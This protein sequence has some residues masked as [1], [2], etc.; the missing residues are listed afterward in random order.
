MN[1]MPARCH[2]LGVLPH[3]VAAVGGDDA[4]ASGRARAG[5]SIWCAWLH[6][7]GVEGGDLVVVA[8]GDDDGLRG[9]QL[10]SLRTSEV[11]TPQPRMRARYSPPSTPDG[12]HH[13]R[14]PPSCLQV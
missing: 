8:V 4:D 13:H 6:R 7:A 10:S 1:G 9:V 11:S 5:T 12:G 14:S 3:R 2:L